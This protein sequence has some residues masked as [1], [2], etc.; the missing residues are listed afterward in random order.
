LEQQGM[1]DPSTLAWEKMEG[2]LP[3]IVTDA[4]DGTVL[5][6]G[7]MNRPALE[8]TLADGLVTFFSRSRNKLWRK[9]ETS[10]NLLGLV[11]LRTDCDR[12]ALLVTAKPHGPTCH[13]GTRSCFEAEAE[14]AAWLGTLER[15]VAERAAASP[16]DSYT[17]RLLAAGPAKAAQKVGEEGVEVALA[18]VSR[19]SDGLAEEAADLLFH[20][21]V[22]LRSRDISITEVIDRLRSRHKPLERD[23]NKSA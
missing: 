12:D 15:I 3:A 8:A 19:D 11:G 2:L 7:Y 4:A 17:A 16:D 14:G 10:G 23:E 22:V 18:A 21:L 5:M 20:L 6:L 1:I 9:G 13:L